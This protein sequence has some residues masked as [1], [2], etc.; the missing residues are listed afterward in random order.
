V[1]YSF[2][3]DFCPNRCVRRLQTHEM[4]IL[5][6]RE[7][8][9]VRTSR[10]TRPRTASAQTELATIK[11]AADHFRVHPSTIRRR[12]SDGELTGYRFG[13]RLI[14]VDLAEMATLFRAVPAVGSDQ[15]AG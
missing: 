13:P 1:R 8:A 15:K 3:R 14:R 5:Q 4:P 9:M 12:I 10:S 11:E 6:R 7:P 2:S